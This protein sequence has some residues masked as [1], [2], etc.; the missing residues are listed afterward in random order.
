MRCGAL[1]APFSTELTPSQMRKVIL[2]E[3]V[4]LDGL[5][6][7]P[8]DSVD[9]VPAS[10]V[11][12]ES[13]GQRQLDFMNTVDAI[14]LGRVTYQMFAAYW[15]NVSSGP[16]SQFAAK[17]NS[18]PKVVFSR[19][20]DTAPWGNFEPA[21]IVSSSA[22]SEVQR[23]KEES[24]KNMV[25]W[26]SLSL[27]QSLMND[28]LIDEYQLIVCPVVLGVGKNLFGDYMDHLD[29]RLKNTRSFDRGTVLLDY[30]PS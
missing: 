11:G 19:T 8:N 16:D 25:V 28:L 4:S 24:G 12:D 15:P 22:C 3:F 13:F 5:A 21:R 23:L 20:L 2:Q 27:A 29:L 17:V 6:A 30:L 26:G 7:G 10:T 9:F 1:L 14:L 18:L